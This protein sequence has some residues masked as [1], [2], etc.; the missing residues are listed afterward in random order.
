MAQSAKL[1]SHGSLVLHD[2]SSKITDDNRTPCSFWDNLSRQWLTR[3]TLQEFDR[4]TAWS[5]TLVP[6]RRTG[7]ES[8]DL[9]KLKRFARHGGPSLSDIRG[10]NFNKIPFLVVLLTDA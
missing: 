3:R 2:K 7:K 4:R 1:I 6:P 9:A 8:I 5:T 10:V